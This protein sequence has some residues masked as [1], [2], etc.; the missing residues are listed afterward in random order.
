LALEKL[1]SELDSIRLMATWLDETLFCISIVYQRLVEEKMD[2][3]S[4]KCHAIWST[5]FSFWL[6]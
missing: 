1:V 4:E 5:H 3:Y 6:W 2:M